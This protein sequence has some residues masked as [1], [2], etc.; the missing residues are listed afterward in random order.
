MVANAKRAGLGV[1]FSASIELGSRGALLVWPITAM[2]VLL[3]LSAAFGKREQ[4]PPPYWAGQDTPPQVRE[5]D[6]QPPA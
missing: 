6:Q 4:D 2:V 1:N 5:Q 3:A